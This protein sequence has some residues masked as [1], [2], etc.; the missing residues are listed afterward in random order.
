M[1]DEERSLW[2]STRQALLMQVDAI[3]RF[4]RISP[5][6]GELRQQRRERHDQTHEI[7]QE[8]ERQGRCQP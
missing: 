6:T 5:R 3:E 4:L 2:I 1:T 7:V 8:I